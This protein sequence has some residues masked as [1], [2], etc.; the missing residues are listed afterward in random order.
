MFRHLYS[1]AIT[2]ALLVN[3]LVPTTTQAIS[4]PQ[5]EIEVG[6]ELTINGPGFGAGIGTYGAICFN[7]KNNCFIQNNKGI[8]YWN[9]GSIRIIIPNGLAANGK[10]TIYDSDGNIVGTV[11]YKLKPIVTMVGDG[12]TAI[13]KMLPGEILT[14]DG[15]G[16][17]IVQRIVFF[18]KGMTNVEGKVISWSPNQIKI[19]VPESEIITTE[20]LFSNSASIEVTVPFEIGVPLTDDP[21]SY[22][23]RYLTQ[24]KI[25]RAWDLL[26]AKSEVIVA[27][28]DD[29]IYQNHED[30]QGNLWTNND[31][32]PGN[33]IDDDN[34]GYTDDRWG[35]DFLRQTNEITVQGNHGTLV[36][37]FIGA[38]RDNNVGIAGIAK[39]V[40]LMS[41]LA[42]N[43]KG[44]G[45][46][47][48]REAIRYATD[49]GAQIIN[50]SLGSFGIAGYTDDDNAAIRYAY[51]RGVV[52]VIAAGNGDLNGGRGYDLTRVPQSPVCNDNGNNMVLGVGA[53]DANNRYRTEWSNYG[54]CVDIYAPGEDVLS[55]SIVLGYKPSNGTS[56]SS[57]IVAGVAALI[58]STYPEMSNTTLYNY[59]INNSTTNKILDAEAIAQAIN[60]TYDP[61]NDIK[62]TVVVTDVLSDSERFAEDIRDS[63]FK[64]AIEAL[65]N[66]GVVAGYD[67]GTFKPK[68]TINRAEFMKIVM[69]ASVRSTSG[70]HCFSDVTDEWFAPFV[71]AGKDQGVVNGY[72]DGSFRPA[73]PINVAEALK[74]VLQ[75]FQINTPAAEANEAWYKPF[76]D[77]ANKNNLYLRTFDAEDKQ[78]TREDM[79]ELVYRLFPQ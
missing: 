51:E 73:D 79:A 25:D 3:L 39:Q 56:F 58:L 44:C 10:I 78:I 69:G 54:D 42:C 20:I 11:D 18:R 57:P 53:T 21:Q 34:N 45:E 16:F 4:L 72:P 67:D 75:A 29:G 31:E 47:A 37:G 33:G 48:I 77:Y 1:A 15:Y 36:A 76:V 30:F 19:E 70:T 41:L 50:I 14:I 43:E 12:V 64:T 65:K 68:N 7:D 22:L 74:I 71:C 55:T 40:Q 62:S 59:I 6:Q 5:T 38:V 49:N 46:D 32:I 61:A 17:G 23:Q 8:I 27:I 52:I 13:N 60:S 28:I 2:L 24:T 9:D 26:P 63:E 66:K 35:Y